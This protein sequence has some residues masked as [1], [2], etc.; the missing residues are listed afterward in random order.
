MPRFD[1][2]DHIPFLGLALPSETQSIGAPGSD[3]IEFWLEVANKLNFVENYKKWEDKKINDFYWHPN[4]DD[5]DEYAVALDA[6]KDEYVVLLKEMF[7]SSGSGDTFDKLVTMHKSIA[8]NMEMRQC[9][10]HAQLWH[11][12]K[13]AMAQAIKTF[14][15]EWEW[16]D[17]NTVEAEGGCGINQQGYFQIKPKKARKKCRR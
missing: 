9:D 6:M 15:L 16:V 14:E 4:F 12:M 11:L 3:T 1:S 17:G 2:T 5:S 8:E 13:N 7:R 10:P